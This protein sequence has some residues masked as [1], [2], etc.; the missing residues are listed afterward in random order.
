VNRS[1]PKTSI[2]EMKNFAGE[3]RPLERVDATP[4]ITNR[5]IPIQKISE[6]IAN[7]KRW[8]ADGP[9]ILLRAKPVSF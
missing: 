2:T 1:I 5:N 3:E 8:L 9:P 6:T 7:A 4:N